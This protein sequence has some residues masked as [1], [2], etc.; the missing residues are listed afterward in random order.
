MEKKTTK[1]DAKKAI[2]VIFEIENK[3]MNIREITNILKEK[4][5]VIRSQPVIRKYLDELTKEKKLKLIED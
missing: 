5:K 1:E 3:P 2:L 4:F